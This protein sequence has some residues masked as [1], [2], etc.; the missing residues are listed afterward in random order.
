MRGIQGCRN[1]NNTRNDDENEGIQSKNGGTRVA[2]DI[3][4]VMG[5]TKSEESKN[6]STQTRKSKIE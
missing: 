6:N 1:N 3:R 2:V 4:V 5:H